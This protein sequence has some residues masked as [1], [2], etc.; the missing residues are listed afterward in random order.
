MNDHKGTVGFDGSNNTNLP[1]YWWFSVTNV[2]IFYQPKT[3]LEALVFWAQDLTYIHLHHSLSM[4]TRLKE[5][6]FTTG[7]D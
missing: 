3:T 7:N 5:K 6:L 2:V 4:Q 1:N